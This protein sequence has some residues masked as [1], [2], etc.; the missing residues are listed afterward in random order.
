MAT[1][2]KV[3]DVALRVTAELDQAKKEVAATDAAIDKLGV[4]SRKA[5]KGLKETATAAD[6]SAEALKRE[7]AAAESSAARKDRLVK[8]LNT[9][10]GAR[11]QNA[12]AAKAEAA[13]IQRAGVSAGQQAMA[14]RQL[15]MQVTDIVTSLASG[16]NPM[17][18]M[19]QQGGQLRD[20]FGGVG[21]AGRALL[22]VISPM[23]VAITAGGVAFGSLALAAFQGYSEIRG[24]EKGLISTGNV[25]GTTGGQIA[26]MADDVGMATG[27][28][29]DAED[30]AQLL[31]KSGVVASDSLEA[32][33]SAAVNLATLT[34][35]SIE[36]TTEKIIELAK[37]PTATMVELNEQYHFLTLEVYEHVKSLEEQGRTT[38]AA[39]VIIEEFA[40]V[41]E[42][43]VLEAEERAGALEKAWKSLKTTIA[44]TWDSIQDIGRDDA[45]YRVQ[46]AERQLQ[47]LEARSRAPVV[48]GG[49]GVGFSGASAMGA[50][51]DELREARE[52]LAN[53]RA[54]LQ[55][56][57]DVAEKQAAGQRATDAAV[58]LDQ[59]AGR[60]ASAEAKRAK[61]IAA[62][63][64]KANAA[65]AD[66]VKSGNQDLVAKIREDEKAIV[67]AINAE[68]EKKKSKGRTAK[69][70][71]TEAQRDEQA[72]QRELD[73]LTKQ[74]TLLGQVEEG[75]K[76][77]SEEAR[78]RYEIENGAYQKA[79]A[80]TKQQ[81]LDQ[82]KLL[83]A[84]RAEREA[85]EKRREGFEKTE[86]AY[87]QLRDSLRTPAE[88]AVETAIERIKVLNDALSQGSAKAG[89]YNTEVG[90]IVSAA[91]TKA[92]TF[93]GLSPEIG[94]ADSEQFRLDQ[95]AQQLETWY[96][97]QLT[98]LAAFRQQ[99]AD[100]SAQWNQQEQLIEAQH[101]QALAD[102]NQAQ[103]QLFL[104][105]TATA[106]DSMAQIAKA[107]GGEQSRT[108]QALFAISKGFAVAQAAVALAQNVA[109]ASKAGFP[110]NIGFIAGALAQGAQIAQL[111]SAAQ[112]ATGGRIRG[113]GT[114]TSDSVP[115]WGSAGEFM[116][117]ERSARE[118]GAYA[119]LED[120]NQRGMAALDDWR[121]YADGGLIA[122]GAEPRARLSE[123]SP[124]QANVRNLMRL[125]NLFDTD[126]LAQ[127]LAN[128][129]ALEKR[130][131]T[132][133]SENGTAIRTE[134][135]G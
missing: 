75:E 83:D 24:Y 5:S 73:N 76:R 98:R 23:T 45:A 30:A 31:A 106:F 64:A 57:V 96:Q 69:P 56:E 97:D 101:Q 84:K 115:L 125:Y 124:V 49:S 16:Q 51:A 25:A 7:A 15:P 53:A 102:L 55:A 3:M 104:M 82:A 4:T 107:Y 86:R 21:A 41:H 59:E 54:A 67:A 109:E 110:Q 74:A 28:F 72:A 40:R 108:Y 79:S 47:R 68:G 81:L 26:N 130:I 38:E 118:P 66:A 18:V 78:V 77:A 133:A 119:F 35:D 103:N 112:Y 34:G 80:A 127:R 62:A 120:F 2:R 58:A 92:P 126:Q 99:R 70:K 117:R 129:P 6:K 65:V 85:E 95:Q 9:E 14:M 43:R 116:V 128:H 52:N 94:G 63:H 11:I 134:W 100:L 10:R 132:V 89:D 87:E 12:Q 123:G 13:A 48:T 71:L 121:G 135:D 46:V 37:A 39:K 111:L 113:P 27:K 44:G 90:K 61:R 20:S 105:Q 22:G 8:F 32:A 88:V 29:G 1:K 122:S 50:S 131:V 36:S 42:E 19:I 114:G 93:N 91:F 60:Y 33:T 17:L